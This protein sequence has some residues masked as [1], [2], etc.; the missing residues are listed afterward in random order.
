M[1]GLYEKFLE[2]RSK[3]QWQRIGVQKRFGLVTPLFSIFSRNSIGI[4]EF[5]DLKLLVDWC[6]ETGLTIIQVLPL[7]DSGVENTPYAA[8]SSF[9]LDPVYISIESIQGIE[10]A[11]YKDQIQKLREDFTIKAGQRLDFK[12]KAAKLKLLKELFLAEVILKLNDNE[13]FLD[14]CKQNIFWLTDYALYKILKNKFNESNFLDWS[15]EFQKSDRLSRNFEKIAGLQLENT[16]EFMFHLWIQW[17][18]YLQLRDTKSYANSKGVFLQGDLP[19][20][21][22]NDSADVWAHQEYFKMDRASGAPPDAFSDIGQRWGMPPY[23]WE[24]I[25]EDS[26]I[27][28][29]QRLKYAENFYDMFRI[30]HAVGLFRIWTIDINESFETQGLNGSFDPED[31]SLWKGHGKHLLDLILDST[32]MLPCAEDLGVIPDCSFEILEEFSIPGIDVQRW[33][34]DKEGA[35]KPNEEYRLNSISI[36]SNHD[37]DSLAAWWLYEASQNTEERTKFLEFLGI[38]DEEN[39]IALRDKVILAALK[40]INQTSSIFSIQ[41]LQDLL[42]LDGNPLFFDKDYKINTPGTVGEQNW[43]IVMP[44]SLEELLSK[45]DLNKKISN[46]V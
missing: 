4:G 17:Q 9:A 37:T 18:L 44:Y 15:P 1:K 31:E 23:R 28:F 42:C 27:Y 22:C 16:E 39:E 40:K 2:S 3:K 46:L 32:E 11:K 38:E 26:Y 36:I 19:F 25:A 34:R 35:Y 33:H 45:K 5:P 10:L 6:L 12:I 41:L 13:A 43:S 7:N 24:K 8:Q 21:V 20:L 14:Y 29:K 30:D